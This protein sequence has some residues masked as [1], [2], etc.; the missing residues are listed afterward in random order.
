[1]VDGASFVDR[2]VRLLAGDSLLNVPFNFFQDIVNV[3]ANEVAATNVLADSLFWTGTWWTPSAT[4]LWGEDPGDPGHFMA[5]ADFLFP[6]A[7]QVSGVDQ[8]EIDPTLLANGT[9]GLGQQLAML[10]AAELPVSASCDAVQC[11]PMVPTDPVTGIT[12]IDKLIDFE[13]V[14]TNFP[15]ADNQL[16]LFSHWLQVPLQDLFTGYQFPSSPAEVANPTAAGIADPSTGLGPGGSVLG[17]PPDAVPG[18]EAQPGFGFPGTISGPDGENLMPWEGVNFQLNPVGPFEQWFQ[19][20]EAPVNLNG[21]QLV[22][23]D[24]VSQALKAVTAGAIV[25]FNPSSPGAPVRSAV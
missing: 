1:M 5:I 20:L 4:N 19:S 23:P 8:P 7:P 17:A 11:A 21:F 10:A 12:G 25:D 16:G 22:S 15:N 24:D 6:F 2:A 3:P 13:K 18:S 9:A 14:F